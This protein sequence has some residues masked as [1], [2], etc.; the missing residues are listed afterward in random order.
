MKR[1][2]W[3]RIL[4]ALFY[5]VTTP[6]NINSLSYNTLAFG[7]V[8]LALVT[9][10]SAEEWKP[11]HAFLCGMFSAGAVL[12][13]PYAVSVIYLR[14]FM[15]SQFF[16]RKQK[17]GKENAFVGEGFIFMGIGAFASLYYL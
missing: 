1:F 14:S 3:V 11:I 4:P 2:G 12:A 10:A 7:F 16:P 8:L 17:Q 9:M 5:F 15:C 6:Y 13:N